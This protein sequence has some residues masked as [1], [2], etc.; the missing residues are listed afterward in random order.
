MKYALACNSVIVL[1]SVNIPAK[2]VVVVGRFKGVADGAI[3][4]IGCKPYQV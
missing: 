3:A 2:V 1:Y 4:C